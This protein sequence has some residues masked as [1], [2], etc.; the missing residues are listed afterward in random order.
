M[1]MAN[2]YQP[3][4]MVFFSSIFSDKFDLAK[5]VVSTLS[6]SYQSLPYSCSLKFFMYISFQTYS[7]AANST[8]PPSNDE[9][10]HL[11]SLCSKKH[12]QLTK[13][14]AMGQ[15]F[16]RHLF[17]L[18]RLAENNNISCN[19]FEDPSYEVINHNIISTS[20][21]SSPAV[22]AGGF[23]PVVK[24]GYGIGCVK[25]FVLKEIE[26]RKYCM[27]MLQVCHKG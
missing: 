11:I 25:Y 13:E 19:I 6:R 22:W 21:L 24:D 10:M 5:A 7:L 8:Q 17:C 26:T 23:G 16:D 14:A 4:L 20:T 1:N 3:N 12:T 9:L 15:G 27:F 2:L 18:R